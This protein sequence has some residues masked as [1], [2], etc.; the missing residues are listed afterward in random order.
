[1]E[2]KLHC[3]V[4]TPCVDGIE[5]THRFEEIENREEIYG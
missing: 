5:G 1:M 4:Y 3:H 2:K